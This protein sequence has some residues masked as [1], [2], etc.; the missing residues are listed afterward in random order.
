MRELAGKGCLCGI[1]L[2]FGVFLT[3]EL[4][5]SISLPFWVAALFGIAATVGIAWFL[6]S[7]DKT[8]G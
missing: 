2:V 7:G 5:W 4:H 1:A 8:K 3:N 6:L